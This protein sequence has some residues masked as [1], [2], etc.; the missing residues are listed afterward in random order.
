[1]ENELGESL[2]GR[3]KFGNVIR[4]RKFFDLDSWLLGLMN[5]VGGLVELEALD[6]S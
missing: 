3:T 5:E 6:S 1:M 4:V 2:N